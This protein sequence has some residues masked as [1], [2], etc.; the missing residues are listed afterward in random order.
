[1][2]KYLL[3]VL[4][5]V[6]MLTCA[7][8]ADSVET[9]NYTLTYDETVWSVVPDSLRSTSVKLEADREDIGV[10]TVSVKIS[11]ES[12]NSYRSYLRDYG[13]DAYEL[14]VNHAYTAKDIA[15]FSCYSRE[16]TKPAID[17]IGRNETKGLTMYVTV[18]GDYNNSLV[19]ALMGGITVKI[20]DKGKT[21]YPWP[22]EG[23]RFPAGSYKAQAGA[24]EL[25]A[26]MLPFTDP[27]VIINGA[28]GRIAIAGNYIYVLSDD[29]L[30][31]CA[32]HEGRL[33][34][35]DTYTFK[36]S[37]SEIQSCSDGCAYLSASSRSAPIIKLDA[38]GNMTEI[39]LN[40]ATVSMH[41]S[42]QWGIGWFTGTKVTPFTVDNGTAA[43]GT[44]TVVSE[45][46]KNV[47]RVNITTDYVILSGT[48]AENNNHALLV[49]DKGLTPV[50]KLGDVKMREDGF[51][52]Y[53]YTAIQTDAGFVAFDGNMKTIVFWDKEGN[54]IATLGCKELFGAS[55]AW[56]TG[57]TI[58]MDGSLLVCME[59]TRSDN[60]AN[61]LLVYRVSGFGKG[62][63]VYPEAAPAVIPVVTATP[64]PTAVPTATP[65]PTAVPTATPAPTAA[66]VE[67]PT[68]L[69]TAVPTTGRQLVVCNSKTAINLRSAPD[70]QSTVLTYIPIGEIVTDM[71]VRVD[72][73]LLVSWNGYV[74]YMYDQYLEPVK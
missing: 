69:P 64:E 14:I 28:S 9:D 22:W 8:L 35:L 2:K 11:S 71:S 33:I 55:Y 65:V 49:C 7:A 5:I 63:T 37:Y 1:M 44:E 59:Q 31:R 42:A 73:F 32:E 58:D 48:T 70:F 51:V 21:D 60:S 68:I 13:Y 15:G 12:C 30:Y 39:P 57:C 52:A 20:E 17:Y 74:G 23:E 4:V 40:T 25:N 56:M 29:K 47:S 3:P 34:I 19:S 16:R 26:T 36:Y 6:L 72:R 66:P 27:M 45:I 62:A 18:E 43:L 24:Y 61:E 67:T 54:P 46:L 50:M 10:I 41:P 38:D 53:V